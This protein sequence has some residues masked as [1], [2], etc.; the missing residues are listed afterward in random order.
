MLRIPLKLLKNRNKDKQRRYLKCEQ[1]V[2]KNA[3]NFSIQP[4]NPVTICWKSTSVKINKKT[5]II[6]WLYFIAYQPL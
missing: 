2:F 1:E 3:Q 4:M 5:R 6:V